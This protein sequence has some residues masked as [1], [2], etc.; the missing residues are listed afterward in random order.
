M[1]S[2]DEFIA[3]KK[4]DFAR[5]TKPVKTGVQLWHRRA[6]TFMVQSD[7]PEK[8]FVLERLE[9]AGTVGDAPT[10]K[11]LGEIE[12]RFGYFIVGSKGKALGRWVWGQFCPMIP[13][14]D[15]V[16]LM[17]LASE[18]GTLDSHGTPNI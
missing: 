6:A 17:S 16:R 8:V 5:A 3:R 9:W 10:N 2:S 12:Y 4:R 18:E 11:S 1:E 7:Y 15:L 14:K 13:A